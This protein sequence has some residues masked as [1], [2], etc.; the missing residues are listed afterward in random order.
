MNRLTDSTRQKTVKKKIKL[1]ERVLLA[2]ILH[3]LKF[4]GDKTRTRVEL[5]KLFR[6]KT[7]Q[8][9]YIFLFITFAVQFCAWNIN[10][11]PFLPIPFVYLF[12]RM[13]M[14][15]W[16]AWICHWIDNSEYLLRSRDHSSGFHKFEYNLD[17]L[18]SDNSKITH[19]PCLFMMLS[20]TQTHCRQCVFTWQIL[21]LES[22]G[23]STFQFRANI[24][25]ETIVDM[26][27]CMT[28]CQRPNI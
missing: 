8:Q 27:V 4:I 16:M 11:A 23:R 25:F 6:P 20:S 28:G 13:R 21:L 9:Y 18:N 3:H 1:R 10:Y 12:V 2:I 14:L 22:L 19:L 17:A 24:G 15:A 26:L 5:C 7:T